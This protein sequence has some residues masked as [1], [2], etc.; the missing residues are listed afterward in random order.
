MPR[1]VLWPHPSQP[2]SASLVQQRAKQAPLE[3]QPPSK[4]RFRN[5]KFSLTNC[6]KTTLDIQRAIRAAPSFATAVQTSNTRSLQQMEAEFKERTLKLKLGNGRKI[7]SSRLS[8]I[9]LFSSF[10][11]SRNR[12][13]SRSLPR[14]KETEGTRGGR[15]ILW[16]LE[17]DLDPE[18]AFLKNEGEGK[19]EI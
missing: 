7:R 1:L 2:F 15:G 12:S 13:R 14:L 11:A 10:V 19:E 5:P 3:P 17:G 9:V 18:L 4:K 8:K 6:S 16:E